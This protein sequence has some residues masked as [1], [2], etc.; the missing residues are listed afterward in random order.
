MRCACDYRGERPWCAAVYLV[1]LFWLGTGE[2]NLVRASEEDRPWDLEVD[3]AW[4]GGA[5]P[6]NSASIHVTFFPDSDATTPVF[7]AGRPPVLLRGLRG[8]G[9]VVV[10]HDV[11]APAVSELLGPDARQEPRRV[12]LAMEVGRTLHVRVVD[13]E[14]REVPGASV[15]AA[16]HLAVGADLVG[17]ARVP[18]PHGRVSRVG[19]QQEMA[20]GSLALAGLPLRGSVVVFGQCESPALRGRVIA[21]SDGPVLL[22]LRATVSH[23]VRVKSRS[24]GALGPD[25]LVLLE[26]PEREVQEALTGQNWQAASETFVGQI[27]TPLGEPVTCMVVA[28][29]H[30]VGQLRLDGRGTASGV[31]LEQQ[32]LPCGVLRLGLPELE[33]GA[34]CYVL[35]SLEP[36]GAHGV[37]VQVDSGEAVVTAPIGARLAEIRPTDP[38][39]T[40][41]ARTFLEEI[42]VATTPTSLRVQIEHGGWCTVSLDPRRSKRLRVSSSH[43]GIHE[44]D[45]SELPVDSA[46]YTWRSPLLRPGAWSLEVDMRDGTRRTRQLDVQV[47]MTAS[48]RIDE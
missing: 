18:L 32:D 23:T 48:V 46:P 39:A 45:V 6:G 10:E 27:V 37:A 15:S 13:S 9:R 40:W 24:S 29:G 7:T 36:G 21:G 2:D 5:S 42:R 11:L 20:T 14:G 43:G 12:S 35:F 19:Q 38:A 41:L 28:P 1:F 16:Y 4:P 8:M 31:E 26:C 22:T 33:A 17:F 47:G 25:S 3:V 44:V 30:K 34:R